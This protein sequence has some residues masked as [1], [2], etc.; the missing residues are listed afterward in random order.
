MI[1]QKPVRIAPRTPASP[2][3]RWGN[4]VDAVMEL[5]ARDGLTKPNPGALPVAPYGAV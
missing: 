4:A 1:S 3:A 2:D 5:D